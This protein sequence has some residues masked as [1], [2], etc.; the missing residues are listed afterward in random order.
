[1]T[2]IPRDALIFSSVSALSIGRTAPTETPSSLVG[3]A[4]IVSVEVG[5]VTSSCETVGAALL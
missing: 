1:M 3:T 2:P 4:A 5:A